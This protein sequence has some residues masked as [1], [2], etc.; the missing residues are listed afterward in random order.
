[1]GTNSG[2]RVKQKGK[3]QNNF[4]LKK[5]IKPVSHKRESERTHNMLADI[6]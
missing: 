4:I 5:Q 3:T 2:D 1:M 6:N